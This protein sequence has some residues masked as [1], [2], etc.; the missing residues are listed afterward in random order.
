MTD[1]TA[2]LIVAHLR[3][4]LADIL[5][6]ANTDER[7]F[8]LSPEEWSQ[9]AVNTYIPEAASKQ[10]EMA[11]TEFKR[12]FGVRHVLVLCDEA[13]TLLRQSTVVELPAV[14]EGLEGSQR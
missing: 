12:R 13:A 6:E 8:G 3:M 10:L 7:I 14:Q 5:A 2:D 11:V 4:C 9:I 1:A